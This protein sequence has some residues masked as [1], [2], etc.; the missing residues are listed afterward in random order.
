MKSPPI[1]SVIYSALQRRLRNALGRENFKISL[2]SSSPSQM[3]GRN[4]S[5]ARNDPL[6]SD[7]KT[8]MIGSDAM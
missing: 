7:I 8:S 1:N 5:F 3:A 4:R 6:T 2:D